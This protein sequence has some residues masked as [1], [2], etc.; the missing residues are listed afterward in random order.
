MCAAILSTVGS[1]FDAHAFLTGSPLKT[2]A[3]RADEG[4]QI[5]VS[6]EEKLE[7]Q[8]A[9]CVSFIRSHLP[10]LKRLR[11]APGIEGLDFR[12][13]YFWDEEVAALAHTLPEELHVALAHARATLTFCVYPCSKEEPNQPPR[14]TPGS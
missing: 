11:D 3:Q 5:M 12:I 14:T 9:A 10:E 1:R 6:E 4:F 2:Y 13:A 8:I 7:R